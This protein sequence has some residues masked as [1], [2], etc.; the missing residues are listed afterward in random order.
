MGNDDT[1]LWDE[2]CIT[3]DENIIICINIGNSNL[4]IYQQLFRENSS[5]IM[6]IY[7]NIVNFLVKLYN[8]II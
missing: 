8:K 6:K 4:R 5:D 2:T 3:N 7:K 1:N